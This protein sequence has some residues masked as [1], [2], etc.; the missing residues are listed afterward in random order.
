MDG[1]WT[2]VLDTEDVDPEDLLEHFDRARFRGREYRHLT[3]A[4]HGVE[5][6]TALVGDAVV[7]GF[8]SIP[9]ALVL[10][11]AVP[12]QFDGPVTVEEKLNG[13]NVRVA[14]IDGDLLAFTRRGYI[15]PYT[16]AALEATLEATAFF[17]DHPGRML[18]GEFVGPENPYT[19]HDYAEVDSAR[20]YV[21]DVRDRATG[22][23]LGPERRRAVCAEYE[24]DAVPHFGT[25]DPAEAA[26][27]IHD[28][29][30][31]LDARG[32]EGVVLKSADGRQA[33]KYTTSAIHRADLEHAFSLPFDYGRDFI[34]TRVI[35][36]A[37][38]A[39]ER[40]EDPETVRERGRDLGESILAPAVETIRAVADDELVG[41]SHTVR[42]D[43]DVVDA[44]LS[45]FRDQGLQVAVERD[46]RTDGERVVEF[47]KVARA[48][49]D[50]TEYY[51]EGGTVD[52]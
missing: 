42:G 4:R 50:K 22:E 26:A 10:E 19:T 43:P 35:R 30:A 27:A 14:R 41:E 40:D 13:Y 34:F 51:L 20:F 38:Q 45:Y 48:T 17:E 25:F 15:C 3:D 21:F 7:R 24:L 2:T 31:D 6:G 1:D 18:C 5:R 36:E 37:F 11:T 52:E 12:A 16:T 23:P 39:V 33:L 28:V 46:E 29:L 32:R 47:T 9:R 8:P 49:Q 44:L